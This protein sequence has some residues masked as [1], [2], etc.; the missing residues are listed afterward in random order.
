MPRQPAATGD[1]PSA[2]RIAR[3]L[4]T[5]QERTATTRSQSFWV[6]SVSTGSVPGAHPCDPSSFVEDASGVVAGAWGPAPA[7]SRSDTLTTGPQQAAANT[8]LQSTVVS[9]RPH[10]ALKSG[11]AR[12][13]IAEN[14]TTPPVQRNAARSNLAHTIKHGFTIARAPTDPVQRF[15]ADRSVTN[16]R[17]IGDVQ[18]ASLVCPATKERFT[19]GR[20]PMF[21]K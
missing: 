13:D 4:R 21:G 16:W 3:R 18:P 20:Y 14:H 7:A 11:F 2:P 5:S 12:I 8:P 17:S 15:P 1:V 9:V 6:Q 19:R 10:S